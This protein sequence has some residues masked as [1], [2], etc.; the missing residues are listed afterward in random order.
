[1]YDWIPD[2]WLDAAIEIAMSSRDQEGWFRYTPEQIA[3]EVWARMKPVDT[4]L[5]GED[6]N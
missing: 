3:E 4:Y 6:Q 1:M 2:E 5:P